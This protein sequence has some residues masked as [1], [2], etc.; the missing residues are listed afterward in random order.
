MYSCKVRQKNLPSHVYLAFFTLS[1]LPSVRREVISLYSL[2]MKTQEDID[3]TML[4][5]LL[6]LS[7]LSEE[8]EDVETL[9]SQVADVVGYLTHLEKFDAGKN[10]YDAYDHTRAEELRTDEIHGM[11]NTKDLKKMSPFF[12][13]GYFQV[14]KVIGEGA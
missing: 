4:S 2:N 7:R 6:H 12:M 11:L 13:D 5:N 8:D 10:P 3:E 14:P 9:R 1:A